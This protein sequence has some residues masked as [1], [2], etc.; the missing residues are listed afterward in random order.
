MMDQIIFDSGYSY[1]HVRKSKVY[2]GLKLSWIFG[3]QRQKDARGLNR[4]MIEYVRRDFEV[5]T[6]GNFEEPLQRYNKPNGDPYNV[7]Q[8]STIPQFESAITNFA[9]IIALQTQL[10]GSGGSSTLKDGQLVTGKNYTLDNGLSIQ[11]SPGGEF[12]KHSIVVGKD[13]QLQEF[14]MTEGEI[15]NDHAS[16]VG[17]LKIDQ[18]EIQNNTDFGAVDI[19]LTESGSNSDISITNCNFNIVSTG[20]ICMNFSRIG[21]GGL[22]VRAIKN[23]Q[24]S[25]NSSSAGANPAVF[26]VYTASNVAA[27]MNIVIDEISNN[28][29]TVRGVPGY[30]VYLQN[31]TI[32]TPLV[33][34][35]IILNRLVN[36]T[37][38]A[39]GDESD[40]FEAFNIIRPG[41]QANQTIDIGIVSQNKF[42]I[43]NS[44]TSQNFFNVH[45][46]TQD[47]GQQLINLDQFTFNEMSSTN[48][49]PNNTGFDAHNEIGTPGVPTINIGNA[50]GG[51]FSNNIIDQGKD[52][53][54]D[55]SG[56]SATINIKVNAGGQT[57]QAA[58]NNATVETQGDNTG[59]I[60][61]T[62]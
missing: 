5:I 54:L 33:N 31:D 55:N 18:V 15:R 16:H 30:T 47:V 40:P 2:A 12:A 35:T 1:D 49:S 42:I 27:T 9:D 57:L 6:S 61:I 13:N 8:V 10:V 34:Q 24:A 21:E 44:S 25:L 32:N 51:F 37:I 29:F 28:N 59:G 58:N 48:A 26:A 7:Q 56:P 11:L 38:Q 4:R 19:R 52:I 62:P 22:T 43:T 45:N 17:I 46:S 36:N 14:K 39:T 53:V 60:T 20:P 3:S 23:T 50:S 41:A